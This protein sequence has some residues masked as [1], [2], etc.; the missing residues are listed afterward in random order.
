MFSIFLIL[1][2]LKT[3]AKF[4]KW[5]GGGLG[6]A[7][8]GPIGAFLGFAVGSAIDSSLGGDGEDKQ[9]SHTYTNKT[10]TTQPNDFALSLMVLVAAV[11]KADGKVL[12]SELDYV[13]NFLNK[14]FGS[15]K[16][17]QHLLTLREILK[18]EVPIEDICSQIRTYTVLSA[19]IQLLHLLFGVA[20]ADGAISADEITIISKIS[21]YLGISSTD[22]NSIKAMFIKQI[23]SDFKILE[24][25]ENATEEE[26]KKAYRKMAVK[27]HPDK[28][29]HMGEEFQHAA[30]DKFQKVQQAYEN[31][32]KAKGIK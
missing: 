31:I 19:R 6:W 5:I 8:G 10:Y 1:V 30:K 22:Y 25:P 11:M 7:L 15:Q 23:D 20:T 27:Y 29:S 32:K 2:F 28:V 18:K 12:K 16:T 14:Q 21:S 9:Q 26:I 3:M 13:K 4:G 17:Q 24:I